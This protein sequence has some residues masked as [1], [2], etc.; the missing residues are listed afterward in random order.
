MSM[1]SV[2][3]E[4]GMIAGG[5]GIAVVLAVVAIFGLFRAQGGGDSSSP[6]PLAV[7]RSTP[8][9]TRSSLV[10][11]A[12]RTPA[13]TPTPTLTPQPT[14]SETNVAAAPNRC[15]QLRGSQNWQPADRE[16][17]LANCLAGATN[18]PPTPG[19]SGGYQP[20]PGGGDE[21]PVVAPAPVPTEP[22]DEPPPPPTAT[23]SL[24]GAA[25]AISLAVQWLRTEA[26][27]TYD[28]DPAA[29]SAVSL[30]GA[31]VVTCNALLSGCGAQPACL[32]TIGLC[33]T[34]EPPHVASARSC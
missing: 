1:D 2:W 11:G 6:E 27:V 7:A 17:F 14:A 9:V 12:V 26:P 21:P 18:R 23:P 16:W 33:V 20:P 3:W 15:D 8:L 22:P 25:S 24:S 34:L 10:Q 13:A 31:W 32:R 5:W 29:C 28:A 30:G 4:R 19:P